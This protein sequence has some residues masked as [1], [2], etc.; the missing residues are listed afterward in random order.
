MEEP[1]TLT[2]FIKPSD[3]RKFHYCLFYRKPLMIGIS[4]FGFL[5]WLVIP[6]Y[7]INPELT[8]GKFP[9]TQTFIAL[10]TTVGL[11][12][13]LYWNTNRVYRSNAKFREEIVY[14][15]NESWLTIEGNGFMNRISWEEIDKIVET[16]SWFIIHQNKLA[17]HLLIKQS[18]TDDEISHFRNYILQIP[19]VKSKLRT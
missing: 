5:M 14:K 1:L 7:F 18:L 10:M 19:S 16:K 13:F 11:P 17:A 12:L 3:Y 6:L 15:L 8:Y 9:F 4:I 2:T